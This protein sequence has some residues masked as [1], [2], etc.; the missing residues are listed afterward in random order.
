VQSGGED[1]DNHLVFARRG[2]RGELGITGRGAERGENGG[3]HRLD[4]RNIVGNTN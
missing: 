2:G 1:V 4:L 3:F